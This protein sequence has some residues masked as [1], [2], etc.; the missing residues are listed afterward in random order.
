[1]CGEEFVREWSDPD[2]DWMYRNCLRLT[3]ADAAASVV[4][5]ERLLAL[6]APEPAEAGSAQAVAA[7]SKE[8]DRQNEIWRHQQ[9][10]KHV[11]MYGGRILH[12]ACHH[13]KMISI[14][15]SKRPAPSPTPLAAAVL[16]SAD[17]PMATE[18][19]FP[20]PQQQQPPPLDTSSAAASTHQPMEEEDEEDD[21]EDGVNIVLDAPM[22]QDEP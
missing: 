5:L 16:P 18:P 20:L 21:E 9:I 1:M 2:E 7:A 11:E 4:E 8:D 14:A 13:G 6:P 10:L 22:K 17:T 19:T 12:Q 3:A 15:K